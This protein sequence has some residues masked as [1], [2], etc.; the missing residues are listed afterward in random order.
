MG[1]WQKISSWWGKGELTAADEAARDNSRAARDRAGQDYEA[2]KDDLVAGGGTLGGGASDWEA[3]SER[4][5]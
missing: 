5:R 4:P 3:D 1:I 2:Y